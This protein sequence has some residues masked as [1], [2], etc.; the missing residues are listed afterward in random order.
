MIIGDI[1]RRQRQFRPKAVAMTYEGKE[2][3]YSQVLERV[4]RAANALRDLGI[5]KGER[6]AVLAQNCHQYVELYFANGKNGSVTTPL[7]YR[8]T[9]TE[10]EYIINN[11]EAVAVIVADD[12]VSVISQIKHLLPKVRHTICI[13]GSHQGYVEYEEWI[14]AASPAEPETEIDE[15]DLIWQMYTSGTTGRPKGA[16]ITHRNLLTNVI[17]IALDFRVDPGDRSLIV[18]PL[19]HAAAVITSVAGFS[20]GGALVIKKDFIIPEVL[21]AFHEEGVTH[22][23]LV[24]AMIQVLLMMPEINKIDFGTLKYIIYGA[25]A[26]PLEVLRKAMETFKCNFVQGFGQ[27]ESV[28]VLSLLLPEDH[29]LEGP[30]K[31]LRRLE[32]A[33]RAVFGT[34]IRIIDEEG[35]PL[36]P[37]E[38]GEI[39]A[40]GDQVMT[41]YWKLEEATS[42]TRDP[43]GR[44][45]PHGR[46]RHD[47]R[48]GVRLCH[49]S[50]EGHDRLRGRERLPAGDRGGALQPSRRRRRRGHRRQGHHRAQARRQGDGRGDHGLLPRQARRLQAAALGGLHR[51]ASEEPLGQGP[52]AR[53]AGA[54]LEGQGAPCELSC[55][56]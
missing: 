35:R 50:H 13:G 34:E 42:E 9:P 32:S 53:T 45:A 23:L 41:G 11:S 44:L 10:L 19:Y 56:P 47:G 2:Y 25:S 40:R 22:A 52:E 54:L 21:K 38:L 15:D 33:G 5:K 12:F 4:N 17:Q 27:T 39:I 3:T 29:V 1:L 30:E 46:S 51:C 24:P 55:L 14:A 16:M 48:G 7:N 8:L 31:K 18:A 37:G 20:Q 36:P 26:I 49:G 28:A 6:V 43:Q